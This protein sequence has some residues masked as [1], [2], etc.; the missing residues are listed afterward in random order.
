MPHTTEKLIPIPFGC[1]D[2]IH[3]IH[4][5]KCKAFDL[6]PLELFN[7]VYGEKHKKVVKGQKGDYVFETTAD[8]Q[9]RKVYT[10]E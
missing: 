5:G 1:E 2:C 6:I 9:Y 3:F 4:S 10:I 8:R 7:K